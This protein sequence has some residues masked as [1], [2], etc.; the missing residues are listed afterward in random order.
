MYFDLRKIRISFY[1]CILLFQTIIFSAQ[2]TQPRNIGL[3]IVATGRYIEFVD[4][5]IKSAR[6]YFMPD[7]HVSYFVFTDGEIEGENIIRI[8]HI[9]MGWPYDTMMRFEVYAKNK[10]CFNRCDYLFALDAD[11]L[12]VD[13]VGSE[14]L[15]DRVATMHPGYAVRRPGVPSG[16]FEGRKISRAFLPIALRGIYFAGGFY[17]GSREEFIKMNEI[18]SQNIHKDLESN[19]IAKWHDESH[20]N[21]YF[22]KNPPT[23]ILSPSYCYTSSDEKAKNWK[24]HGKFK[25]KLLAL[26]KDHWLYRNVLQ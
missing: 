2:H 14:I 16:D 15:H 1:C 10:D 21:A 11:M 18:C 26:E 3:C 23:K 5:L 8:P 9:K 22:A 25:K 24:I 20:L 4:E 19:V 7:D 12:F 17:G 6:Q 13:F